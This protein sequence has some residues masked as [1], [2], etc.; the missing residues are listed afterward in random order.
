MAVPRTTWDLLPREQKMIRKLSGE[1]KE[2]PGQVSNFPFSHF[3]EHSESESSTIQREERDFLTNPYWI[4][5]PDLRKGEVDYLSNSEILFWKDLIDKYLY[6]IDQNKEEQVRTNGN[7]LIT[8]SL[9][10]IGNGENKEIS[11][12][13]GPI[14]DVVLK[15]SNPLLICHRNVLRRI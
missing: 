2:Y 5:D 6:P 3:S 13:E 9:F 1:V 7:A 4:E 14:L 10:V 15:H 11:P 8:Q 12:E